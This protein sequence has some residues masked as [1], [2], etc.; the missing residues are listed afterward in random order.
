MTY[1]KKITTKT[2]Y[3]SSNNYLEPH[4]YDFYAAQFDMYISTETCTFNEIIIFMAVK[5]NSVI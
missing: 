4:F 2:K 3:N 1:T 5:K